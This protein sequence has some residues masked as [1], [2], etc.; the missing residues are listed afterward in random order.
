M[1]DTHD[2]CK[3]VV[4]PYVLTTLVELPEDGNCTETWRS[5]LIVKCIIY[6]IVHF[7]A[8]I[9]FVNLIC[10]DCDIPSSKLYAQFPLFMPY[11]RIYP[12]LTDPF[13][14]L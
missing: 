11:Q 14:R 6:S 2:Y 10:R 12:S 1:F 3:T 4:L 8:L 9:E 7:L 5:K 13:Y